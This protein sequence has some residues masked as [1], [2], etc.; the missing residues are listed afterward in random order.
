MFTRRPY[1]L[2][3]FTLVIYEF[4]RSLLSINVCIYP[5]AIDEYYRSL[6]SPIFTLVIDEYQS[7][8]SPLFTLVIDEYQ[9]SLSL[10]SGRLKSLSTTVF[11]F[12]PLSTKQ[13]GL[14]KIFKQIKS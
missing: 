8:L 5:L 6:L 4:Q 10:E 7:L 3:V 9:R 12:S 1:S 11:W 2:L 14:K 13:L